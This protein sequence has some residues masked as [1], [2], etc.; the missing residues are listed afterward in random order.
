MHFC[1]AGLPMND[2]SLLVQDE[3]MTAADI[4]IKKSFII[5]PEKIFYGIRVKYAIEYPVINILKNAKKNQVY[6]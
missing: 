3:S 2:F 1:D 5:F 4:T 6:I